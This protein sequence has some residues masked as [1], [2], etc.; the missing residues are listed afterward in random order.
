MRVVGIKTEPI[1]FKTLLQCTVNNG[2][3]E[4]FT[5]SLTGYV[6]EEESEKALND[7]QL[8]NITVSAVLE[9]NTEVLLLQGIKTDVKLPFNIVLKKN[10]I[11]E[12]LP[13]EITIMSKESLFQGK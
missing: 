7:G 1:N 3:N 9:D 12:N 2:L 6:S 5:V 4:H 13:M 8:T 10:H 11:I